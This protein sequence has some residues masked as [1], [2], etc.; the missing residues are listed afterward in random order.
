[1]SAPEFAVA[2]PV[3]KHSIM[4]D[5]T[6]APLFRLEIARLQRC[7]TVLSFSASEAISQPFTFELDILGDGL[8]LD[9][10]GLMY[11]PAS[12]SFGSRKNFHGQ[13]QGATRKHYQPGPACYKLI[14]G[15]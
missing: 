12:L 9:L 15:A 14:I 7:F 5:P 1:M 8:D 10:T 11:K 13:I 6:S 4:P 3:E 2:F